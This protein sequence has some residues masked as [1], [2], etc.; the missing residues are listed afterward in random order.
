MSKQRKDLVLNPRIGIFTC[1]KDCPG[2]KPGC[3]AKCEKYQRERTKYD[4]ENKI[5]YPEKAFNTYMAERAITINELA[6]KRN[7]KHRHLKSNRK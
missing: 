4:Q 3:H 5:D 7:V 6:R 1:A 2:R